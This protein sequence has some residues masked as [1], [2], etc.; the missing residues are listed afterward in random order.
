MDAREVRWP[1][2][3][4]DESTFSGTAWS[5]L[6][7]SAA[8]RAALRIFYVEFE[9]GARTHWHAHSGTQILLVRHGRCRV[10]REGGV[11]EELGPGSTVTFPPGEVHWHGAAADEPAAHFAINL[12]NSHTRW[13]GPVSDEQAGTAGRGPA[14]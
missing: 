2:A 3:E 10:G 9:P 5:A 13:M 1:L 7:G 12:D 14:L 4:A 11:V 6:L 8:D